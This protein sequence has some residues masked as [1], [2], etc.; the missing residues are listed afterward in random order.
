MSTEPAPRLFQGVQHLIFGYRLVDAPL[1][2]PLR[3][4]SRERDGFVGREQRHA[5]VLQ[6]T[7]DR[8]TLERAAGHPGDAFAD[9]HV[10]ASPGVRRFGQQVRDTAV[11]WDGDVVLLVVRALPARVQ[12]K[13]PRLD[14]VEVGDDDP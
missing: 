1:Q 14:V 4:T 6:F 5:R 11:T 2:N 7:L 13:P 8:Q 9:H 10:E 3:T 12:F